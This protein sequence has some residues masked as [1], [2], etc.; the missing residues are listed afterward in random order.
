MVVARR[1]KERFMS[2]TITVL[3]KPITEKTISGN[4]ALSFLD[5]KTIQLFPF[6]YVP[7]LLR[8]IPKL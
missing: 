7:P 3:K 8:L 2:T 4:L 5:P 1:R 6:R